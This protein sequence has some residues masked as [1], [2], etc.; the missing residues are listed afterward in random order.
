MTL[1]DIKHAKIKAWIE[2]IKK[3]CT[4]DA[5]H[6]CYGT[7]EEYDTLMQKMVFLI[8]SLLRQKLLEKMIIQE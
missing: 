2:E 5:V 3:M 6:I 1:N 7:K 8:L 4:P